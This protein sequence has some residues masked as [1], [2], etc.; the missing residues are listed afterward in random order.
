MKRITVSYVQWFNRKYNR[1]GHLFQNRYKSEPI[2]NE[3]YLMAVLRYIRQNPI[4][5]GMVKEAAKYNWSS[6]NEYLKMY[7][8]NNYL[9]DEEIMKAYFDSKKSFIEFHNQMSKENYM[10]YENINK[11]SDNELLELFKKKISIDEFYKISL[12]D[13]A[14]FI[15]DLYHETGAS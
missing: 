6:Y 1:V 4:K 15:K 12:T 14:K 5:A 13:R 2:E 9:I 7:D 10:D 8:S 3:R 11:Y